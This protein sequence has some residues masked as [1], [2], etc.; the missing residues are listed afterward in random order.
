MQLLSLVLLIICRL[1]SGFVDL[2]MPENDRGCSK[3]RAADEQ[4]E[5]GDKERQEH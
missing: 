3:N 1:R 2:G 4:G 5:I